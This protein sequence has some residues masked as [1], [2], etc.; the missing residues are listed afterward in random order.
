M[1]AINCYCCKSLVAIASATF[2]CA[3]VTKLTR[4]VL[5]KGVAGLGKAGGDSTGGADKAGQQVPPEVYNAL[6]YAGTA[7]LLTLSVPLILYGLN[8]LLN[9]F[10]DCCQCNSKD[11]RKKKTTTTTTSKLTTNT[12]INNNNNMPNANLNL[13]LIA[14]QNSSAE[15]V[16][17]P[18]A[19]FLDCFKPPDKM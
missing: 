1:C 15:K 11:Q 2:I 19:V 7:F 18:D 9:F 4:L 6:T 13:A 3:Y 8:K 10:E 5:C 14:N 16:L 12:N 17:Q